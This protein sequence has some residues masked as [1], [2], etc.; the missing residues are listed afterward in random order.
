MWPDLS[1]L[2]DSHWLVALLT[3]EGLALGAWGPVIGIFFTLFFANLLL[4]LISYLVLDGIALIGVRRATR[5]GRDLFMPR[6]YERELPGVSMLLTAYNEQDLIATA[7]RSLLQL[8]Y[9]QFELIVIHDG[10]KDDTVG[11]MMREFD[12][13]PSPVPFTYDVPCK[14]IKAIYRSRK[15]PNLVL[16]DKENGGKANALNAGINV[17]RHPLYCGIDA[18]SV[19]E[20]DSL[21]RVVR[22]FL[23]RPDT[24]AAGGTVR[25]ANGC[26]VRNG[27]LEKV[28]LPRHPL[29]AVQVLEYIRAFLFGRL[30]WSYLNAL[31]IISGAFG[32][33]RRDAVVRAGG[34]R[35]GS[36]GEDM[37]LVVRLH[38]DHLREGLP[39]SVHFVPDPVCWTDAPQDLG[40]LR[41]QRIRW[42]RGLLEVLH[43]HRA[44]CFRRGSGTVGW[45]AYPFMVVIEALAP[46]LQVLGLLFTVVMW[47][48]GYL[49]PTAAG[50]FLLAEI[51]FGLMLSSTALLLEERSFHVYPRTRDTL[52][53]FF[54]GVL[55][56]LGYRQLNSWWRLVATWQWLTGK[57]ATWGAM[58]RNTDWTS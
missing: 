2:S 4:T 58:K 17:A 22:I 57:Q 44:L 48:L 55:E 1:D 30:G 26:L 16:I 34:Y 49:N 38:H 9:P 50:L 28:G 54:W 40:T 52:I 14:P 29:A 27:L 8:N 20:R 41:K 3:P 56:S 13:V 53:L 18:D 33:F 47:A 6:V 21:L 36:M 43:E 10:G 31:L 23:E 37:E 11:V 19:L 7:V 15:Y 46:I 32:V 35:E 25:I 39:Y 12:M 5:S 24:V 45:L 51:G 42:Q